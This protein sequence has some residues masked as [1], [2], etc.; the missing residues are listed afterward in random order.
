MTAIGGQAMF[1]QLITDLRDA[2]GTADAEAA[3][4][5]ILADFVSDPAAAKAALADDTE[6]DVILF[7]DERISIWFCRF[8]PGATVPPHNHCMSATIG[9]FQGVERNDL[10]R[11][12]DAAMPVLAESTP[13]AAGEVVQIA[14]DAVHGVTC[15]S[16]VPS[17]AIHVYLGALTRTDRSLFD[18]DAGVELPFTDEN[19]HRLTKM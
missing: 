3:V 7:E 19:Y 16:D 11:R 12:D 8:Q 9:V 18:L 1:D 13:I 6:D 5:A 4:K 14:A 2:A 17:E 15:I 10:Y